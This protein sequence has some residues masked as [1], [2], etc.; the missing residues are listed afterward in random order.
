MG[1]NDAEFQFLWRI[2]VEIHWADDDSVGW[3][4]ERWGWLEMINYLIY[5]NQLIIFLP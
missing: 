3:R 5:K 1:G 2:K 4:K